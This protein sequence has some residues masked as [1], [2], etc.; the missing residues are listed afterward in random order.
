MMSDPSLAHGVEAD[1][2]GGV[3][4]APADQVMP[5]ER[6]D[7][8]AAEAARKEAEAAVKEFDPKTKQALRKIK[9]VYVAIH[10]IGDQFQYATIQQVANRLGKY[11]DVAA[12]VSLG[13][14]H[15]KSA[16]EVGFLF[17][18]HP[19]YD[20]RLEDV[21]LAEIYWANIPRAVQKE[22]YTLEEAKKWASSLVGRIRIRA[23]GGEDRHIPALYETI[24]QIIAEMIEGVA[25]LDRLFFLVGKV[26]TFKFRLKDL[27]DAFLGDVQIVT[28]F[29]NERGRLLGLFNAVMDKIRKANPDVDIY[30]ISHSE[31]TVVAFLGLLTAFHEYGSPDGN[32]K[33]RY[34]WIKQVRGLMTIGSP[35]E[36]HLILWPELFQPFEHGPDPTTGV[37]QPAYKWQ[38]PSPGVRIK[39]RNYYDHGDPIAYRLVETSAWMGRNKWD[40]VFEFERPEHEFVFSRYPFP[41]KAH[42]DYWDDPEVFGHF[43]EDVVKPPDAVGRF[44]DPPRSNRLVAF[45]SRVVPYLIP[46]LLLFTGVLLI[47]RGVR[48]FLDPAGADKDL[49]LDTLK[50]ATGYWA[51]FAGLTLAARIP[52]LTRSWWAWGASYAMFVT[53]L[54]AYIQLVDPWLQM[55]L[56]DYVGGTMG[57]A[58][59]ACLTVLIAQL[60]GLRYPRFGAKT[61]ILPGFLIVLAVVGSR[62]YV[63]LSASFGDRG[64]L[65]GMLLGAVA[66]LYLWWLAVV[67]FDLIFVWHHYVRGSARGATV[68][69]RLRVMCARP[70]KRA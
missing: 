12:P 6:S 18:T 5:R 21:G 50:N 3:A 56:T 46:A 9:R 70:E 2:R 38:P 37:S 26:T 44:G 13:S 69:D 66:F 62:I 49:L 32:G 14:F 27:L 30:I 16:S 57:L 48:T 1:A 55:W 11:Y 45:C 24:E 60:V 15:S 34:G 61:L 65:W 23:E 31:G 22:G 25:V 35:I 39:W 8:P 53:G 43:I 20:S 51:L 28:D 29:E 58:I 40:A 68:M 59:I 36:E 17:L 33:E 63:S 54:A 42:I 52:R 64:S 10:G 41:G 19:P 4:V 7:T 47:F 67:M